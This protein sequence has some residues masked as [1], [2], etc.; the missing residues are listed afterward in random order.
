MR[1]LSYA[2]STGQGFIDKQT[3]LAIVDDFV[4]T[5]VFRTKFCVFHSV[6]ADSTLLLALHSIVSIYPG[7]GDLLIVKPH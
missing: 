7:K 1:S 6:I 5:L 4:V 3:I 2:S